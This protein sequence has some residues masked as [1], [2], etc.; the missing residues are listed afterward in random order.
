MKLLLEEPE[1]MSTGKISDI[2]I[3]RLQGDVLT[4]RQHGPKLVNETMNAFKEAIETDLV[5]RHRENEGAYFD[6]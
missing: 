5:S 4:L 1:I 3:K 2:D 6:F